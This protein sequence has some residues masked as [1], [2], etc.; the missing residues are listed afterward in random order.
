MFSALLR[1]KLPAR[2]FRGLRRGS[3]VAA[4][5]LLSLLGALFACE[6]ALRFFHPKYEDVARSNE[7]QVD[8]DRLYSRVPNTF[9]YYAHPDTGARHPV[10]YN[11]FGSRQ[12]RRFDVE[13]L[14]QAQNVAF[15]GDSYTENIRMEAQYSFTEVLD[16]LLNFA[17]PH[18]D[19]ILTTKGGGSTS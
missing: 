11:D 8:E 19:R 9:R 14:K 17:G 15:F 13:A 6:F 5:A 1:R 4:L 7:Y 10:I 16:F 2:T 3:T 18:E 12:H